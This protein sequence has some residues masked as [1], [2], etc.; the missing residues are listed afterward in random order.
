MINLQSPVIF[1][2]SLFE[3]RFTRFD[4]SEHI[5]GNFYPNVF[6]FDYQVVI[7]FSLPLT[8]LP[9]LIGFRIASCFQGQAAVYNFY[10]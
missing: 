6:R 4:Q 3:S 9:N 8:N 10:A 1:V 2:L 5:L 7:S